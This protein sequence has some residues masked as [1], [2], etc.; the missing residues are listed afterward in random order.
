MWI[1]SK[2]CMVSVILVFGNSRDCDNRKIGLRMD[3]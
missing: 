2:F 1:G 3:L